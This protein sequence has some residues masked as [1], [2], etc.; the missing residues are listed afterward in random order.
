M[1]LIIL[2]LQ[3]GAYSANKE[4]KHLIFSCEIF[5][6]LFFF[7]L[8]MSLL[9]KVKNGSRHLSLHY[10]ASRLTCASSRNFFPDA[11]KIGREKVTLHVSCWFLITR[12]RWRKQVKSDGLYKQH[13]YDKIMN[14]RHKHAHIKCC[15]PK[16]KTR[17]PRILNCIL[18]P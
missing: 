4:I 8:I 15:G 13:N 6:F 16:P 7:F 17:T 2:S 12:F 11:R 3:I 18:I 9:V 14:T 1:L 5:S 10:L